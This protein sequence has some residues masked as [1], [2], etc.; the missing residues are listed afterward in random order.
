VERQPWQCRSG[1]RSRKDKAG[2]DGEGRDEVANQP[3][4]RSNL[5]TMKKNKLKLLIALQAVEAR[6]Q[7]VI[8]EITRISAEIEELRR[9][10]DEG[11]EWKR[12]DP[13]SH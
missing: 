13:H 4:K 8:M 5:S 10:T 2:P 7:A 1:L 3:A 6:R 11:E 12:D 9:Q